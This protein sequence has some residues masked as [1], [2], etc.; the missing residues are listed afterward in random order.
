MT[1]LVPY[2]EEKWAR[3]LAT[4]YIVI[5]GR[6]RDEKFWNDEIVEVAVLAI[7]DRYEGS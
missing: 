6:G 5:W 2:S 4:H 3:L 7:H 1:K